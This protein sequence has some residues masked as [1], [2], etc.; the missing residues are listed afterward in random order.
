MAGQ[1]QRQRQLFG[2]LGGQ[3]L[4]GGG[5]GVFPSPYGLAAS[6]ISYLPT[7][8]TEA[9]VA[10]GA[11][12]HAIA[13]E[14]PGCYGYVYPADRS[15]CSSHANDGSGQPN[16]GQWFRFPASVNCANYDATPFEDMVCKAV[17]TYGMVVVD[18]APGRSC[19]N[20]N[21]PVTGRPRAT[22]APTPSPPAGTARP[23]TTS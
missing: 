12:D 20:P 10:S 23:S 15:D 21:S 7:T 2:V 9:D 17:Q 4:P 22:P 14:L 13:V 6:G 16:E 3:A 5:S 19:S 8:I 11:I 1:P 18:Y